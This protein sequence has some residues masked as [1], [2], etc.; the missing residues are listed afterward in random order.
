MDTD[1]LIQRQERPEVHDCMGV[2][3]DDKADL[4]G[5]TH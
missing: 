1:D 3:D 2:V 4:K 5:I